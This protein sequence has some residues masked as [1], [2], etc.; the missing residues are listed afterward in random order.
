MFQKDSNVAI[1]NL[2]F[3][4]WFWQNIYTYKEYLKLVLNE[5]DPRYFQ[6]I[7]AITF[8]NDAANEMKQRIMRSLKEIS[9]NDEKSALL[10]NILKEELPHIEESEIRKRAGLVFVE[11]L[12]EYNDFAVKTIDSFVNQIVSSFT[13]DLDLP[14][15]YEINLDT[16]QLLSEAVDKLIDKIGQNADLSSL[17]LDFVYHKIEEDKGWNTLVDEIK[18]FGKNIFE[19]EGSYLIERNLDISLSEIKDIQSKII[20]FQKNTLKNISN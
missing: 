12:H 19:N 4:C 3:F 11:I 15:N 1:Q 5:T 14:Y 18:T 7:L 16:N 6:K 8:T 9:T 10:I 17:L 2:R 20:V 13:F